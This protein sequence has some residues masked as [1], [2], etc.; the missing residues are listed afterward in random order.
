MLQSE[1]IRKLSDVDLELFLLGVDELQRENDRLKESMSKLK[2]IFES[3]EL[4]G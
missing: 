2:H 4:N 1:D 3:I